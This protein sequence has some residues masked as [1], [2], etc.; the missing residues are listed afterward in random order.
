MNQRE[1]FRQITALATGGRE[2]EALQSLGDVIR[3]HQLDAEGLDKAGLRCR[4]LFQSGGQKITG[5][6]LILGQCTTTWLGPALTAVAWG[7]GRALEVSDGA[8]DNVIQELLAAESPS[9]STDVV[10][11]VPWN[12]RLLYGKS[13]RSASE[14]VAEEYEFWRQV[15][16]LVDQRLT[17]KVI[18]VGY[19]WTTPGA[20][21]Y[22][23]GARGRRRQPC[24]RGEPATARRSSSRGG[25]L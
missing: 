18:Q 24:A 2:A 10:V 25:L 19:D 22:G 1:Y 8:Y 13:G 14:R 3:R 12:S 21:G 5:R 6:V 11:L 16:K 20:L 9:Q 15:W 17:A 23:L 7:D 4:G